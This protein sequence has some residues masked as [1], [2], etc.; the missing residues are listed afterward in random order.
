LRPNFNFLV[1][2]KISLSLLYAAQ[3]QPTL[4][5]HNVHS[6]EMLSPEEKVNAQTAPISTVQPKRRS[7]DRIGTKTFYIDP[8]VLREAANPKGSQK[9]V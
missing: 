6:R 2:P 8:A 9:V 7:T 5:K 4:R 1:L 3:T